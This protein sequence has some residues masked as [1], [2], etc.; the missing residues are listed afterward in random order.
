[1][2]E[3]ALVKDL[4][5]QLEKALN[6]IE[7]YKAQEAYLLARLKKAESQDSKIICR[8]EDGHVR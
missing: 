7:L 8:M 4:R 5:Q 1:M 3:S 6:E 2:E